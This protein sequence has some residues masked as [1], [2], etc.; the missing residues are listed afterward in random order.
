MQTKADQVVEYHKSFPTGELRLFVILQGIDLEIK[1][2]GMRMTRRAPKCSTIIRKEF[3]FSGKPP[4][5]RDQFRA[6]LVK[7]GVR[8]P[9][10]A[11]PEVQA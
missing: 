10:Q 2:P 7:H 8:V 5:L 11:G 3:G 6:L 1:I 9:G 4:S